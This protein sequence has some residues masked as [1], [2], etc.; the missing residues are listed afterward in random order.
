MIDPSIITRGAEMA[1]RQQQQNFDAMADLSGNFGRLVLGRR[2]NTLSQLKNPEERQAFANN[3]VFAPYLNAQIKA[4]DAAAVKAKQDALKFDADLYNTY[5][6]GKER[7]ANAD[8][9]SADAGKTTQET[10]GNRYNLGQGVWMAVASSGSPDAGKAI[11]NRQLSTGAIDQ[12]T[13]D[14]LNSQLDGLTGQAPSEIQK[15]AFNQAKAMLD[16]KYNFQTKD[17]EATTNATLNGQ[18][19]DYKL[20]QQQLTQDDQQFSET[21]DFN[22]S[23]TSALFTAQQQDIKNGKAKLIDINGATYLDYGDGR[24][25]I[26]VDKN[27]QPMKSAKDL[28]NKAETPEQKMSRVDNAYNS[29]DAAKAAARASQDAANLINDPGL[30]WGTGATSYMG[31]V[32][33]TDAKAFHSKLENLKAQVFLPTVKALQGMGA[34]SNAEGEKIAAAVANLDPKLGPDEMKKQL[35]VLAR[36]MSDAAVTAKNKTLNY[37]SRGGTIPINT[38]PQ[39]SN[40]AQGNPSNAGE[41]SQ[42]QSQGFQMLLRKHTT[43]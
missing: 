3:S 32:P 27:G 13:F 20:G 7:F 24:G 40:A 19:L 8:K 2:L 26:Y 35:A 17:N 12:A 37:A 11:L 1:Q 22:K 28:T 10:G 23:Q 38:S 21:M 30:Y 43:N 42:A 29:A 16:P 33:G 34:L 15:L 14:S 18:Q 39:G 9:N 41:I 25:E 31:G 6:Q 36:Q 5:A 4:D